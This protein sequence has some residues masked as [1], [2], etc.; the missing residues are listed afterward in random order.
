VNVFA[1]RKLNIELISQIVSRGPIP[2]LRVYFESNL[3]LLTVLWFF[4]HKIG[5]G[6]VKVTRY[7]PLLVV[8]VRG[9]EGYRGV[10]IDPRCEG[11]RYLIDG[12]EGVVITSRRGYFG[13]RLI[14]GKRK[15]HDIVKKIDCSAC[16]QPG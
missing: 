2:G 8:V 16:E 3:A 9:R 10:E 13:Y 11:C 1:Q 15:L 12:L 6:R 5:W 7:G 14:V 4:T